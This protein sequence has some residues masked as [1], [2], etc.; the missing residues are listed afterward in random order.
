MF[1]NGGV[2]ND[3]KV[4]GT[5]GEAVNRAVV[6]H[7]LEERKEKGAAEEVGDVV[8]LGGGDGD[9]G[10]VIAGGEGAGEGG[11]PVGADPGSGFGGFC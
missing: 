5:G 2:T 11:E 1:G 3:D 4:S 8:E 6:L 10:I 9:A 7:P